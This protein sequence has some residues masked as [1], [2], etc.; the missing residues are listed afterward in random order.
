VRVDSSR[1]GSALIEVL[2]AIVLLATAGT[3]LITLIGQTSHAMRATLESDRLT[4]RASR[5]LDRLVLLDRAALMSRAGRSRSR[6]WTIDVQ[7]LGQGLFAVQIA[8]SETTAAL[9][10]TTM[11]RPNLDSAD[12]AR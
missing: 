3:A 7:P 2:V 9:L 12:V 1:R 6:G 11:Y 4:R 5:E 8:E 10:R